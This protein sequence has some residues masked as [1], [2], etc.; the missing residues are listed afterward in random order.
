M[1]SYTTTETT[2][3]QKT[4]KTPRKLTAAL[5]ELSRILRSELARPDL[6]DE[7]ALARWRSRCG[8]VILAHWRAQSY[9]A[10]QYT[11]LWDFC[12]QLQ[13]LTN[14]EEELWKAC[15]D[16]KTAIDIA[17]GRDRDKGDPGRQD[18]EGIAFQHSHGLSVYFPWSCTAFDEAKQ[19][20]KA[21]KFAVACKWDE[22]LADY[23]TSTRRELRRPD[24]RTA[25]V[26]T[27][28][29][30]GLDSPD[31]LAKAD[32]EERARRL[33]VGAGHAFHVSSN[34]L[35]PGRE[36]P[37]AGRMLAALFQA[38]T[39]ESTKNPPTSVYLR[40]ERDRPGK[41]R[42]EPPT[43]PPKAMAAGVGSESRTT[44]ER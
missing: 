14:P 23:V 35:F 31:G 38:A 1:P 18:Y 33:P 5:N 11:D 24:D 7:E 20:Y 21:L 32:K 29:I 17:V 19:A 10:E 44:G 27:L 30:F 26:S 6:N 43:E 25:G 42:E 41:T 40:T 3:K 22:F 37:R 34:A 2:G 28:A 13:D 15:E 16:I 4:E 36:G 9:K 39:S 12:D 8:R